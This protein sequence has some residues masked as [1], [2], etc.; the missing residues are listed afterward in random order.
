MKGAEMSKDID[1]ELEAK[2]NQIHAELSALGYDHFIVISR[3]DS[4]I[5]PTKVF[6]KVDQRRTFAMAVIERLK[7]FI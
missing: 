4:D 7:C 2:A 3:G 1:A 6:V 5:I